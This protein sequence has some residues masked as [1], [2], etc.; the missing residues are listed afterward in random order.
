MSK[1]IVIFITSKDLQE[2]EKIAKALVEEQLVA[3][4]NIVPDIKSIF[5]WEGNVDHEKEVL[6]VC[7]T[8]DLNYD[9]V[10]EKV[11]QLHSYD[12]PEIIVST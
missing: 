10:E 4:V 1:Y 9:L 7:K 12:V 2:A 3:C 5:R 6:L 11:K 8:Q